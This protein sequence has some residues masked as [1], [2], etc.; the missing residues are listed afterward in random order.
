M[1]DDRIAALSGILYAFLDESLLE[2]HS[3]HWFL[4]YGSLTRS[5]NRNSLATLTST[6]IQNTLTGFSSHTSAKPVGSTSLK[7]ARLKSPFHDLIL[8]RF[9]DAGV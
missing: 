5:G 7:V 6:S 2:S 3:Y 9:K 4:N 8:L 1:R